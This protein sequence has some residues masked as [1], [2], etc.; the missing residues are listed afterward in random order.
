MTMVADL[1]SPFAYRL[2]YLIVTT[3]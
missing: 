2:D 3:I 1:V